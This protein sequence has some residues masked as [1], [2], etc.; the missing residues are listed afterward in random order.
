MPFEMLKKDISVQAESIPVG[1]GAGRK[2]LVGINVKST[3][4]EDE[5]ADYEWEII[6]K[7]DGSKIPV[8]YLGHA[9]KEKGK[10]TIPGE[11][12]RLMYASFS[13][14]EDDVL[15]RFVIN[16]DGTSPEEKYLGNNVFEA[17]IKY[18][19]SI[20]EYGEYDIPYNVLSRDFSFNLSKRPSVADLGSAR[21]RW[22]G[23]I[24]GEFK[25]I[26]DP[27]D[28]LFRKYSEQNNPPVNEVR[29]SRV[30][31]NPIVNFTIERRDFG[32]DPE[33]RK[34]LDI[35]PSTPVVKNGRLFSEGY[36]QGWDVYECGFE[37]CELCP[38]KVL[39]TAPFNEVTKDLTFNV[40][41]YNGM[42]NI[43][44]KSFRNEIE[45]N[46][47]DSLNKKMYW[48]SEAYNFNVIRWMCR[49][50]SNGKEYGWTPVD[51]KY[52]RTFKQQNSGDIQIKIN[53]PM[54]IE[55]MQAR[56]AARQG[57]NR[58]DLYDKAVFPT[59][60]DLQRFD[61]PIKSG[62]YF[63]PAGKYSFKVETVTYKPVPYDT[64]EHKD[65][66]NAVI[67][68]FNYETDLMYINDYR[69]AV[70]IKGELLPERG[71]TFSTRPGR[72]TARDNIGINGIELVT[73][74][75]RNSDESRYTKK[76][77]EIYHEHISGG[78]THE[79]WKMVM[80]GYEESNTLSSRD[81]Y[82]YRE[83][84]KPG[85]K[86]YKITETTEVDIIINKDNINTFT[87]AHMPDGEYYIRVW[88]DNVDLGSSS[89]A[90]S[91]LGTLSG[92]MLDEMYITVKGSMYDD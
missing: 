15:V 50:D 55:Y 48:E 7:S 78:N 1:A 44:S 37:D 39:R 91:S 27:R 26:R 75:D 82:K 66:V 5:T 9:T 21:G 22:S 56:E 58:K 34:W 83:Y 80:E 24:T 32:D 52:Q 73:V 89:H 43:P 41:V 85:Q 2:V 28:G 11:N 16:E 64:Q 10:I 90:Y 19:E 36:I 74:L 86:M 49:L 70:N 51:G 53:S 69:E 67:N 33:G 71:S 77:E 18:V 6:K 62:Y 12:E 54:E 31:R 45:N 3:F 63:N 8:E 84:V 4:T 87:H 61:Y 42:K 79:Y 92:V 59:D 25:I 40:Y 68:S 72:L 35:N 60:I 30:E 65:I 29:R 81:N 38:H 76:V 88:M 23:N 17:E 47:V 14:P 46:R 13:M 57:I 20:F